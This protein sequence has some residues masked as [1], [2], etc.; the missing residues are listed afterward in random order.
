M[1][2]NSGKWTRQ[3]LLTILGHYA[4][5]T[6]EDFVGVNVPALV[7]A[8]RAYDAR[9]DVTATRGLTVVK[10]ERKRDEL[11]DVLELPRGTLNSTRR[12]TQG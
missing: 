6:R 2:G 4:T 5:F 7:Q 12:F 8:L 1:I 3:R 11:E 10:W 9:V